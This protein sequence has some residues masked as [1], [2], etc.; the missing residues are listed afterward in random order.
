MTTAHENETLIEVRFDYADEEAVTPRLVAIVGRDFDFHEMLY[1]HD[2]SVNNTVTAGWYLEDVT[3]EEG[4]RL[5]QR[6][7]A[8]CRANLGYSEENVTGLRPDNEV[9][10][11]A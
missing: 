2:G 6:L 4:A 11:P 9:S 5:V 8:H 10:P 3:P 7:S 1:P